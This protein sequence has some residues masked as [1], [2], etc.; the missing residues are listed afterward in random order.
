MKRRPQRYR[1]SR[2]ANNP[3]EGEV[4]ESRAGNR[5]KVVGKTPKGRIRLK[6]VP[7]RYE[8][9]VQ[10]TPAMLAKLKSVREAERKAVEKAVTPEMK[11]MR[12]KS[13]ASLFDR[14]IGKKPGEQLSLFG[15]DARRPKRRFYVY[16][17]EEIR[18][19]K[20]EFYVGQTGKTP[21]Q[22]YKDHKQG[23]FGYLHGGKA[24]SLRKD[25]VKKVNPLYSRKA[26]EMA[27]KLIARTLRKRGL[28]VKGGH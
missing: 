16:V 22:R 15:G 20:R 3:Q 1:T 24:V 13:G 7:N 17:I 10:W 12:F 2:D 18:H 8:G 19:G 5:W 26:A 25:L 11:E 4:F 14:L 28:R 9:E 23:H 6:R 21:E 27:E